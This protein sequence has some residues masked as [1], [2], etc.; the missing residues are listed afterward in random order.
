[1][2]QALKY[3]RL[4]LASLAT[5]T[6]LLFAAI[7]VYPGYAGV[8]I[9][10]VQRRMASPFQAQ[11]LRQL[12]ASHALASTAQVLDSQAPSVIIQFPLF[13]SGVKAAFPRATGVVTIVQG[14]PAVSLFDSS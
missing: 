4:L 9:P 13:P 7:F 6:I 5:L 12:I 8:H 1:M 14:N 10:T 11:T 2:R 3:R